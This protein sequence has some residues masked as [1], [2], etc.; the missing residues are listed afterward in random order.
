MLASDLHVHLDGSLRESTLV[1][2]AREVGLA[3]SSDDGSEFARRLRFSPGMSLTSCL[4]RFEVTVGLLQ[5]KRALERVA[6]E[7][8]ADCY[9]DG[10]R[11]A[12][13]RF[14][15]A[16][17]TRE[18]LSQADAVT[19]V[20]SGL[21]VGTAQATASA[22]GDRMS[23]VVVVSV[24]EGMSEEQT[25]ELVDLA[26]R[27]ADSGVAGVD[28]AGDEALFDPERH[29]RPFSRAS[30]AGLG[31]TVHAGEGGDASNVVAAVEELGANRIGHGVSASTDAGAMAL[32]ADR[33]VAVEICLSSNLHT[34]AV[35]SLASHPLC[36]LANAG[37]PVVLA[38]DNRFFSNTTLS[39][40][41]ELAGAE[42]GAGAEILLG[43]IRTSAEAAFLP[44]D[45]RSVLRELYT[46]S[47]DDS[48]EE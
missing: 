29:A 7:L 28:L 39:H 23:A 10:V 1:A 41:Y 26:I 17:H 44:N 37:V 32:L 2:L 42:A 30:D 33:N 12:E 35:E 40:E 22:P 48:G 47:A 25:G 19:A 38:T 3:P 27:F 20:M 8:V 34:G 16:L 21:Q 43:S 45:Q 14:C 36:V 4:S 5:T 18:G 15:P 9:L 11:H 24:L 46:G 6:A 13:L 31:V